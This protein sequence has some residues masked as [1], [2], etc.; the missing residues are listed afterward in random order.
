VSVSVIIPTYYRARDLADLFESL[1]R[2]TVKPLEVIVV[3]DTPTDEVEKVCSAYRSRFREQGVDL[4]YVRNPRTRSAAAARNVG[5]EMAR[6]EI[7][8][9]VDSDVVLYPD[10]IEKIL[11]VFKQIPSALGVQGWIVNLKYPRNRFAFAVVNSLRKLF[12]LFHFSLNSCRLSEYPLVLTRIIEC[13]YLHGSNMA[14]RRCVFEEFKFDENLTKY[15]YL[16]DLLLTHS[17][18][19]KHPGSL[20]ITPS[21]KCIHKVSEEGRLEKRGFTIEHPHLRACRKYVLVKLFGIRGY[22][23]FVWQS[24]GLVVNKVVELLAKIVKRWMLS[25]GMRFR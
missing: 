1:L 4:I 7:L 21:A 17:I 10:Y 23:V 9:F 11:E 14:L 24:L 13:E 15:S 3:D 22:F 8:L 12:K 19:Q 16:E 18:Y 2:Q 25:R 5:A 20:Y 6:G